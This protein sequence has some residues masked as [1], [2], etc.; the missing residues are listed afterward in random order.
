MKNLLN[1]PSGTNFN[2]SSASS[3]LLNL[4]LL[5]NI[6]H[7]FLSL[8]FLILPIVYSHQN[9]RKQTN[10]TQNKQYYYVLF[11]QSHRPHLMNSGSR[12]HMNNIK[13][14]Q[15]DQGTENKNFIRNSYY[16]TY[17]IYRNVWKYWCES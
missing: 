7:L 1:L 9:H 4:Q 5:I 3:I 13:W 6:F 11:L 15:S 10:E 8:F 2:F 14:Y 17:Q 12:T 16:W